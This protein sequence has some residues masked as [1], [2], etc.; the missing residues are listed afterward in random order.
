MANRTA[1]E[2]HAPHVFIRATDAARSVGKEKA[3]KALGHS[4]EVLDAS[5]D[6]VEADRVRE[7][8]EAVEK[9]RRSR[10]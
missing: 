7:V 6:H 9:A 3:S 8:A 2:W 10:D 5:Y 4:P 1:P